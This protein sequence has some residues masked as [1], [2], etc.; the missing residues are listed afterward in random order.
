M[1][2]LHGTRYLATSVHPVLPAIVHG[3]NLAPCLGDS[4]EAAARITVTRVGDATHHVYV[5]TN[6][7]CA[8][9]V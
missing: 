2:Q 6:S 3:C 4:V 7:C 5:E 8:L 9:A 1:N